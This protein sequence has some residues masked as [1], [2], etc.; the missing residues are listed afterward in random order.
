MLG[1][2]SID[3]G[4]S[5]V[6]GHDGSNDQFEWHSHIHI[7][8]YNHAACGGRSTWCCA[9]LYPDSLSYRRYCWSVFAYFTGLLPPTLL[10][11]VDVRIMK[12][13]SRNVDSEWHDALQKAA[14]IFSDQQIITGIGILLAGH[15]NIG[16]GLSA[17]QWQIITYL[18]WMSSNVHLTTLTLLREWLQLNTVLR[19]WRVTGMVILMVLLFCALIPTRSKSWV[20]VIQNDIWTPYGS[21]D[22]GRALG[23]PVSCF[24]GAT[25]SASPNQD[26]PWAF[27]I[28]IASYTW[29]MGQLFDTSRFHL[30]KWLRCL[31]EWLL[32]RAAVN[33]LREKAEKSETGSSG[34]IDK[35]KPSHRVSQ[36]KKLSASITKP[37][38]L[39][40]ISNRGLDA[41]EPSVPPASK[42]ASSTST[43]IE[44]GE[45][46]PAHSQ[47]MSDIFMHLEP[48]IPSLKAQK[49]DLESHIEF[50]YSSRF[51]VFMIW[52]NNFCGYL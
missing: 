15:C 8:S 35:F 24:W 38:L 49:V 27:L 41:S 37:A 30:K 9:G 19:R 44:P 40:M 28:L 39:R 14:I 42:A 7:H 12:A 18:A 32:E 31:P 17:Y 10:R 13:N 33:T 43:D 26:A 3:H 50:M 11:A 46:A 52:L 48:Q 29:K 16:S 25:V 6:K 1:Q 51:F 36:T 2:S 21:N 45:S 22:E 20:S 47:D 23:T 4:T 5:D 34:S